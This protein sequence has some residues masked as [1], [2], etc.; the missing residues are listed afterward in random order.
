[1]SFFL[2]NS[3]FNISSIFTVSLTLFFSSRILRNNSMPSVTIGWLLLILFIP[4]LGIP[5]YLAFGER[6]LSVH[7]NGKSKLSLRTGK[8]DEGHTR[9]IVK[10]GV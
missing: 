4:L 5:L 2:W 7:I 9:V 3:I 1:M 6:K 8:N 10:S